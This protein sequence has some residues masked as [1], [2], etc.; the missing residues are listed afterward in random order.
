MHKA[1]VYD[2]D[3]VI[4]NGNSSLDFLLYCIGKNKKIIL[5]LPKIFFFYILYLMKIVDKKKY[6]EVFFSFTKLF[7]N[8]NDIL[9]KFWIKR[10]NK[11]NDFFKGITKDK[12]KKIIVLSDNVNFLLE[13]YL[14]KFSNVTLLSTEYDLKNHKIIGEVCY[15]KEKLNRLKLVD[16]KINIENLYA[17]KID[18]LPL[19]KKAKNV[20]YV[21]NGKI[22]EWD[23]KK[24]ESKHNKK[25]AFTL[26]VIFFTFYIV[27]GL[28]LSYHYDFKKNYGLLFDAD[29]ARVI[30]DFSNILGN[31]Y[32]IRVHPLYV[33]LVQPI[34]LFLNGITM[35]S[36]LSLI[37]F[38]AAVGGL[39]VAVIYMIG[40]IF[41]K[42]KIT[43]ILISL[44][45][46]FSFT[47]FVFNATVEVYNVATLFL[48][49]L[50]YRVCKIFKSDEVSKKDIL[51]LTLL[52]VTSVA[53]TITNYFIFLIV[54]LII[55]LSKKISFKKLLG[56]NVLVII[57]VICLSYLQNIVW[58]NT[59][60]VYE[61]ENN[62]EEEENYINYDVTF[63]KVKTVLKD[64][65]INPLVS[66]KIALTDNGLGDNIL[67]FD[68]ISPISIVV[69]CIFYGIILYFLIKNFRK[70]ILLNFGVFLALAFNTCL[71]LVY[72]YYPFLYSCHFLYLGMLLFFINY[73]DFKNIKIQKGLFVI[74][75][76]IILCE[77]FVNFVHF[78]DILD[79]ARKFLPQNYYRSHFG[80]VSLIIII[81]SILLLSYILLYL[82]YKNIKKMKNT[83]N[84]FYPILFSIICFVLLQCIFIGI[85]TAPSYGRLFG[86]SLN[87][88]YFNNSINL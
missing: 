1:W 56:I 49:L 48:I 53:F 63:G 38:S 51:I 18:D 76:L 77:S 16:K 57:I 9:E 83:D 88:S 71:H 11:I 78:R 34:I 19:S 6:K 13:G 33:I 59:T 21:N 32:R 29:S 25:I 40:S 79:F 14:K 67:S 30:S 22:E 58:N 81:S 62:F 54:S 26:F 60:L 75:G 28:F 41:T 82:I 52:G 44:V 5:Y 74:L 7:D 46:G 68:K 42:N 31:H 43:K 66:S 73:E 20:Y 84:L 55:L 17:S 87:I 39:S 50:W 2:F 65:Y 8:L 69:F 35:D 37:I 86:K 45:F 80:N 47:N 24:L 85:S 72:G 15:G 36:M 4:Y 23:I 64:C 12:K 27:L 3:G 10:E 70:N 61:F